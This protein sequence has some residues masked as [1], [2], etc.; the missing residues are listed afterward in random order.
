MDMRAS[1]PASP[2][3]RD[4]LLTAGLTA[5][6]RGSIADMFTFKTNNGTRGS[7]SLRVGCCAQVLVDAVR[8]MPGRSMVAR[9]A[10]QRGVPTK[11]NK[12]RRF[13]NRRIKSTAISNCRSL[14]PQRAPGHAR[15]DKFAPAQ[16]VAAGNEFAR[17]SDRHV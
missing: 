16:V 6:V 5:P 4:V 10:P 17:F 2:G 12:E 3:G 13:T 11:T 7:T 8:N 15:L 9:S 1:P 14:R